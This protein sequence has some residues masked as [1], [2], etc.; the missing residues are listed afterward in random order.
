MRKA[1]ARNDI[2]KGKLGLVPV[3]DKMMENF[4]S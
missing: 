2:I 4:S 3:Q 1:S